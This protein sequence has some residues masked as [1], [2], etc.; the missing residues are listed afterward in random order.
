MVNHVTVLLHQA[1][2]S[3]V[4]Q[5]K[6][7]RTP[8]FDG[9]VILVLWVI[10]ALI[11]VRMISFLFVKKP[12]GDTVTPDYLAFQVW[13]GVEVIAFT[14]N[15]VAR[16]L[17]CLSRAL[18][19]E[20]LQVHKNMVLTSDFL[21]AQLKG[22]FMNIFSIVMVPLGVLSFVHVKL[23]SNAFSWWLILAVVQAVIVLCVGF[24]FPKLA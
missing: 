2:C 12:D 19:G 22:G 5:F 16:I 24:G 18:F 11:L 4:L 21:K 3:T 9:L 10:Q 1:V 17:Y 7:K 6:S 8:R 20:S 15:L 14:S 13:M 23:G